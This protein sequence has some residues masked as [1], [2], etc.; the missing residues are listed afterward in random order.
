MS[1]YSHAVCQIDG[2]EHKERAGHPKVLL[3]KIDDHLQAA[4]DTDLE[5]QWD[6]HEEHIEQELAE[7]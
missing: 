4:H 3:M 6:K 2:C 7:K 1:A 5:E